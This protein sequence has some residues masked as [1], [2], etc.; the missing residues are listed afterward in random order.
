MTDETGMGSAVFAEPAASP[1]CHRVHGH[2]APIFIPRF[3][4]GKIRPFLAVCPKAV[5]H[6][7]SPLGAYLESSNVIITGC[8]FPSSFQST[9]RRAACP[10]W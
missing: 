10:C 6:L 9:T 1:V 2:T 4:P 8:W 5:K 7:F 3:A